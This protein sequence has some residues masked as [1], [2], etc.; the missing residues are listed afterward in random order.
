MANP[1]LMLASPEDLV[2][3]RD[4][5]AVQALQAMIIARGW[6]YTAQDGTRH[7]YNSMPEY[8]KAAYAFADVM[9]KAREVRHG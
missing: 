8:A 9:L 4:L 6:G 5:F 3:L 7:N 1:A 2:P